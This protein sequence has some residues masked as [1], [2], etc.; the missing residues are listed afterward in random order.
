M[1]LLFFVCCFM[2]LPC[3]FRKA[4]DF[5]IMAPVPLV[6][7]MK[8]KLLVMRFDLDSFFSSAIVV[9]TPESLC[10]ENG[11]IVPMRKHNTT[12]TRAITL[13]RLSLLTIE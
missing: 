10:H 4:R 8:G 6:T 7:C 13:I 2:S 1:G 12:N 11:G 9:T 5:G 3:S